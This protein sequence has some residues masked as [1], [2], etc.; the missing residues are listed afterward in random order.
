MKNRIRNTI[1]F[2]FRVAV[3]GSILFSL[4]IPVLLSQESK[5]DRTGQ[6]PVAQ[7]LSEL[8]NRHSVRIFFDRNWFTGDSISSS[9]LSMPF[10]DAVNEILTGTGFDALV[11]HESIILLPRETM[12]TAAQAHD[13]GKVVVGNP[14][15]FGKY[16]RAKVSGTVTD[17]L[18][19]EELIGVLVYLEDL[20]IGTT[21]DAN[22]RYNLELPAGDH[23]ITISYVGYEPVCK[24]IKLASGGEL[25]V[26]M[27]EE[28]QMIDEVTIFAR[29]EDSNI[30]HTQMSM[31]RLDSKTITQLPTSLGERDILR[32][33]TLLPGIQTIGEFGSGFHVRGGSADQNLILV[34][35]VPLFNSSHLF[36]LTSLINPDLVTGVTLFKGGIPAR[37]GERSSSVMDIRLGSADTDEFEVKGGVGLLNSRLS[38]H[39]PLPLENGYIVVGGRSS[40]SDWLLTRIPDE[41]LMNSS[42]RFHDISGIGYVPLNNNN[43]IKLFG[44]YSYDGF[45][46]GGDTDYNYSSTLG[47]IH[48]NSIL[49]DRLSS[50]ML[51]GHS[52]YYYNVKSTSEFNPRNSYDLESKI[53]YNNF[54][55]NLTYY[56]DSGHAL[57]AGVNAMRYE[58]DQG[59]VSPFGDASEVNPF[60]LDTERAVE[61]AG[62][63][64]GE[65]TISPDISIE[66]GLRYT[67]FYKLGP[68]ISRQYDENQTKSS[69]TLTDSRVFNR[70]E[71]MA[72]FGGLEPR[73]SMR[74][75]LNSSSSVKMSL[76]R[77]NQYISLVSNTSLPTPADV[78]YLSNE[79]QPP[80]RS[81]QIALGLFKNLFSINEDSYTYYL[82][83][84]KQLTPDEGIFSPVPSQIESNIYCVN[85][86]NRAAA[87]LFEASSVTAR[88]YLYRRPPREPHPL[89]RETDKYYTIPPPGCAVDEVPSFWIF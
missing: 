26:S 65:L 72:A 55:W 23:S 54:R 39:S 4:Q 60:S 79:H 47:S 13:D 1:N 22:G 24:S 37:Y 88:E 73:I 80:M 81:D 9:I 43:N 12:R 66:A 2:F 69:F 29:R 70:N 49:S 52:D 30:S 27:F 25:D 86:E 31:I 63:L 18:T 8:G 59:S 38:L 44:Y 32:S 33:L 89:L 50:S 34:E 84:N 42:A 40:Y 35:G 3:G 21:T 48:W 10:D 56:H 15:E 77:I 45:G 7:L 6:L 36:G 61:M 17:D 58:I 75:Q 14:Y 51:A 46:F 64:N 41:D 83:I 68:G 62:Y 5:D 82:N 87:G 57:E 67:R 85:D 74:Y 11:F 20:G 53:Q 19:G 78:W 16:T 71:I 76:S 28:S